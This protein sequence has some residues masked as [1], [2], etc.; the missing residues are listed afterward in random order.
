V[1]KVE[2]CNAVACVVVPLTNNSPVTNKLFP[3]VVVPVAA[4]KFIVVA[5]GKVN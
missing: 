1:F 5:R 4:P 3:T 2:V